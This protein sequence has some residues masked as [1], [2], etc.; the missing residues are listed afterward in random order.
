[1]LAFPAK[2]DTGRVSPAFANPYVSPERSLGME[3]TVHDWERL[4]AAIREA[5]IKKGF[6]KRAAF[7]R[8]I[9]VDDSTMAIIEGKRAGHVSEEMLDFVTTR[10]GWTPGQ[11]RAVLNGILAP[12]TD[13]EVESTVGIIEGQLDP[14]LASYTDAAL[15][16]ELRTRMLWMAARLGGGALAFATDATGDPEIVS[17]SVPGRG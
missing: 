7:A 6:P 17:H 4:A 3:P 11:W 9:D 1:M 16:D 14:R 13:L 12:V 2:T 8:S 15:L 10:L 5:R